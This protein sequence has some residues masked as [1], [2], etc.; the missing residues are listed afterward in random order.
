[1][2]AQATDYALLEQQAAELMHGE[3]DFLANASNLAALLFT[4]LEAVNWAGFYFLSGSELVLGPFN[5]K[6]ACTRLAPGRGVCGAAV[7]DRES[8]IV[9]DVHAFDDHIACDSASRSELVVPL[10][11]D[12]RIFGVLDL[13]SPQPARF[14]DE[15]REALERIAAQF[16]HAT[17]IP[18]MILDRL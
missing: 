13:D 10:F 3:R 14:S 15:D 11:L 7:R 12:G 1:M 16:S 8:K 6:P 9:D 17:T 18:P 4:T 2:R 5:G